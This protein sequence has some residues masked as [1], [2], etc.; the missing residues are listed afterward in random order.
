LEGTVDHWHERQEA[1][2]AIEH[3]RGVVGVIDK[4]TVQPQA[5]DAEKI[6]EEIEGALER[7]VER[8][9]KRIR[10]AVSEGVV[11]LTGVVHSLPE[12][13]AVTSAARFTPGVRALNDQLRIEPVR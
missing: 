4:L 5:V 8:E 12:K 7:R 3:L 1:Q 6:R 2:S 9:A 11:T 13:E 10:V